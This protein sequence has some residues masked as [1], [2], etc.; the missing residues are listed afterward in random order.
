M[1]STAFDPAFLSSRKGVAIR[2]DLKNTG[3]LVCPLT[4]CDYI[5]SAPLNPQ[6]IGR[7]F[8]HKNRR[9][10]HLLNQRSYNKGARG[11]RGL[12][13]LYFSVPPKHRD[14]L[15]TSFAWSIIYLFT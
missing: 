6:V 2:P 10:R 7:F 14:R 4:L 13:L 11:P 5:L 1:I 9:V 15:T 12:G 8:L 3:I